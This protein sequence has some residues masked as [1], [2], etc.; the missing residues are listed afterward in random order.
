MCILLMCLMAI[1]IIALKY[2]N[3]NL[4]VIMSLMSKKMLTNMADLQYHLRKCHV[5]TIL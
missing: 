4:K 3:L 2:D 1:K 5:K